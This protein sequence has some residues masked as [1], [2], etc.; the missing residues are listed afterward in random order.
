MGLSGPA[1]PSDAKRGGGWRMI[2]YPPAAF[3]ANEWFILMASLLVWSVSLALP[4]RFTLF[5]LICIWVFNVYLAQ[6]IDFIIG[7]VPY[8]LYKVNDY[9][10]YE[11][12][13]LLLYL[14]TFPPAAYLVLYGYDRFRFLGG[15]LLLYLIACGLI[16]TGL[17]KIS[18]YFR[19][20]TYNHW[21][22]AYSLPIYVLIFAL[23]IWLFRLIQLYHPTQGRRYRH[24][25]R[26]A[27]P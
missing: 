14:I 24:K 9:N 3:N 23:N 27:A 25:K 22:L 16:T 10:E 17:E 7:K 20:F 4:K 15:K 5:M 18:V 19:V 1:A 12:F 11:Y 6:T 2:L 21:G 8:E 13:D 26:R